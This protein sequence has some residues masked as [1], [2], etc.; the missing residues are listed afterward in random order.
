MFF[1]RFAV[2]F[3]IVV[4]SSTAI[5]VSWLDINFQANLTPLGVLNAS[6]FITKNFISE[7]GFIKSFKILAKSRSDVQIKILLKA[8]AIV[9]LE[10]VS[11]PGLRQFRGYKD[12]PRVISG[13]GISVVST[14]NGVMSSREA[15]KKK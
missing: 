4:L 10:R 11:R 3:F 13:L 15:K 6:T 5:S 9:G 1:V 2:G 14:S 8:D 7:E 12:M